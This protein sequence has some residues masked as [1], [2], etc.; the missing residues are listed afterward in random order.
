MDTNHFTGNQI[1]QSFIDFFKRKDHRFVRSSSLVPGGDSTLLFTNAGMVQFKDVF[2]GT[3]ERDYTRAVN[4]QKCMRVAGKHNDLDDVGRNDTHHTFFEMLGNWSFG[5]YYKKEAITWAWELLTEVWGLEKN[6]L[7]ATVFEDQQGEIPTDQEAIDHWMEQ[8][9]FQEDHLFKMG[10]KENFWEMGDT[11]PCGPCSELHYDLHPD[12]GPVTEAETLNTDRFVEIWNLVF[13]QY[14]RKG[15]DQLDP[16]PNTHVDT[17]LGLERVVS[18]LQGVNSN[19]RT[20]LLL[21][22]IKATQELTGHS[23]QERDRQITPYRVIA[24]HGR[25]AAFLIADGVVPGNLGRNYVCRMII[26]RA[27]RFGGHLGLHQPFLARIADEVIEHYQDAYPELA[28]SRMII[29]NTITKEEEQFQDTLEN[30]TIHLEDLLDR[31]E[32]QEETLLPGQAAADLY[33]T[34]GMP[35]EI[36]QDIAEERGFAV[37]ESGFQQAMEKHRQISGAGK[38]MG[39]LG[40]EEVELYHQL[41]TRL[42]KAGKLDSAGVRYDPYQELTLPGEV[43]ALVRD[44]EQVSEVTAGDEVR[45]VVPQTPFYIEAGGQV[46][47]TGW[48]K[49]EDWTIEIEDVYQPAAGM[50]VHTGTTVEGT[51]RAGD[52]VEV[53][54]DAQRRKDIMRNHTGTHL[55]HAAL[56]EVIGEHARQAG[57]LVAPDRLRFDFTHHQAVTAEEL[58]EIEALVNQRILENHSLNIKHKP[59]Q[60]AIDEGARALFG[61]KYG[62]EVR[63]IKMGD[64]SY[65]LCGGT[66]CQHTGDVGIFLITSEGSAAA[67][68]RRIEAVTGRK[69]VELVQNRSRELKAAA[70]LLSTGPD[71][72]ADQTRATLKSLSSLEKTVESLRKKLAYLEL[73]QA[74]DRT[75]EINGI[76]LLT[77]QLEDAGQDALRDMADRFRQRYPEQ[78]AA[79]LG[80]IEDGSPRMVAVVTEDLVDAGFHAGDLVKYVANQVGGG[81]GG[82]PTLAFAGGTDPEKLEE[83]LESVAAWVRKHTGENS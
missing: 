7:Y 17:G 29:L 1:R 70:H 60:Q 59:L 12:Q 82:R 38:A 49:G 68:I 20:D 24:D 44:G 72:V 81:G 11:G 30:A 15:P 80:T 14:N 13:M 51:A 23:D 18:I 69:A 64:F 33:T 45:V 66:H 41:L 61:E 40:G 3:D 78:A 21:P 48:I 9:G 34:Y 25:A 52:R 75:E 22:L 8:P 43:L 67:G 55:L 28:R 39:D 79:V 32:R 31:L 53:I 6:R 76:A 27:Y 42:Q 57:S 74:L 16:L 77:A 36:T 50:I 26:R 46:S 63:T 2:L 19:Y 73:L 71:Q 5:D 37:E 4:S 83:A 56:D 62:E 58:E 47:D 54:V 10:R 65:E 35:L